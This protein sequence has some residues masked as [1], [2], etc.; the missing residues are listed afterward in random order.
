MHHLYTRIPANFYRI[1]LHSEVDDITMALVPD[2]AYANLI[3]NLLAKNFKLRAGEK[4]VVTP[5]QMRRDTIP[6]ASKSSFVII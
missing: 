4:I 2:Q 3:A 5:T 6:E 1:I